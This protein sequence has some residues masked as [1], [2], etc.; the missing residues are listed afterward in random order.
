MNKFG[1]HEYERRLTKVLTTGTRRF[2][3][4]AMQIC[5]VTSTG[6]E[7]A[8]GELA[9]I[10]AKEAIKKDST[11]A[12]ETTQKTCEAIVQTISRLTEAQWEETWFG[13]LKTCWAE[14]RE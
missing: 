2:W 13:C 6:Q 10:A 1:V 11:F 8:A 7:E 3:T 12:H 9:S 4:V 5:I 14:K